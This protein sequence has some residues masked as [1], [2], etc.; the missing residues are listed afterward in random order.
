MA[1]LNEVFKTLVDATTGDGEALISRIEG[2]AAAGQEGAIGFAF[3]DSSGNV[4]L[5]QLNADGTIAVSF[6]TGTCLSTSGQ[7]PAGSL[8][9]VDVATL[10]LGNSEVYSKIE[11]I[12]SATRL[13]E[14]T[15][16][17]DD[18][19][20]ETILGRVLVGPGQYTVD[21]D[22]ACLMFT[23]GAAGTQELIVRGR[24]E[25]VLTCMNAILAASQAA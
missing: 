1:N 21:I 9:D 15:L 2:E 11:A 7:V 19:G 4:V 3:K 12:V 8:T 22:L 10:T 25:D 18:N 6:E 24:N 17:W 16:V 13:T 23:S 20:S 14:Y 5:P